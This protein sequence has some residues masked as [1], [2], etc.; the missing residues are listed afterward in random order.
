MSGRYRR[1]PYFV[2]VGWPDGVGKGIF[3]TGS[4]EAAKP[5]CTGIADSARHLLTLITGPGELERSAER[6]PRPNDLFLAHVDDGR[7]D[8][9]VAGRSAELNHFIE[10]SVIFRTAVGIPAGIFVHGSDEDPLGAPD[11]GP[12]HGDGEYVRISERD[13]GSRDLG[14]VQIGGSDLEVG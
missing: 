8:T 9:D 3:H 1:L 13:V 14:V 6:D 11:L 4:P 2:S 7:L 5:Q 10:R 12:A